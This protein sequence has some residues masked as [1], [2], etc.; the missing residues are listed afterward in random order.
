M[1]E[2]GLAEA[3]QGAS[4][5]N[6]TQIRSWLPFERRAIA[7][8]CKSLGRGLLLGALQS[9]TSVVTLPRQVKGNLVIL[10]IGRAIW[11]VVSAPYRGW[12]IIFWDWGLTNK[13]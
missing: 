3:E 6:D 1:L 9:I 2:H 7:A 13:R 12:L 8:R 4:L 5:P 10:R 11:I